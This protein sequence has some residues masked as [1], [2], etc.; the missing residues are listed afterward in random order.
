MR[1]LI[2]LNPCNFEVCQKAKISARQH[3]KDAFYLQL[4]ENYFFFSMYTDIIGVVAFKKGNN[5]YFY[6]LKKMYGQY[7]KNILLTC[8]LHFSKS[9][10]YFIFGFSVI[11]ENLKTIFYVLEIFLP[12]T[13]F[14]VK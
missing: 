1:K 12:K 8:F 11:T 14:V 3:L 9:A 4:Y 2:F 7:L 13:D 10:S 5:F 6:F